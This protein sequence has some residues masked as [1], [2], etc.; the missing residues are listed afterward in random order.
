MNTDS[1]FLNKI[2][3]NQIQKFIY[4]KDCDQMCLSKESMNANIRDQ[5][6]WIIGNALDNI[7]QSFIIFL[8]NQESKET[9]I[10]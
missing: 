6:Q 1:G 2:L 4:E 8:E 5:R 7:R 9:S 3:E 10:P